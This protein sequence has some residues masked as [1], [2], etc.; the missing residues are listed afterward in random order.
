MQRQQEHLAI[1]LDEFGGTA[2]LVTLEDLLEEIV[3]D[4]RDEHDREEPRLIF[5]EAHCAR[6]AGSLPVDRFNEAFPAALDEKAADTMA[7]LFV[8][9]LGRMPQVGDA[10]EEGGIRFTVQYVKDNR[11]E[12]LLGE[13]VAE[14]PSRPGPSA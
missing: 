13:R 5:D 10:L 1:V 6:I 14:N 9:R 11:L 12:W 4:I 3:G 7:G 8:L 2:G